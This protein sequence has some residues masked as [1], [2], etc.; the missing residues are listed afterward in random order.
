MIPVYRTSNMEQAV[1]MLAREFR[2]VLVDAYYDMRPRIRFR[3]DS[4]TSRVYFAKVPS[5]IL[6]WQNT[7]GVIVRWSRRIVVGPHD[8]VLFAEC[9]R[10]IHFIDRLARDTRTVA[11]VYCPPT[12]KA[13]FDTIGQRAEKK[14]EG[15]RRAEMDALGR[16]KQFVEGSERFTPSV[17]ARLLLVH[18]GTIVRPS[19]A[20][21]SRAVVARA[22]G[23]NRIAP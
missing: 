20:P 19:S 5:Q 16:V 4:I 23:T 22:S 17:L 14:K 10:T 7:G 18:Q 1:N 2:Q 3:P 6:S 9:P 21:G 13:H 12:W 8:A 15:R 11:V